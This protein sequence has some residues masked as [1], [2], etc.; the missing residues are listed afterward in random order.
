[1]KALSTLGLERHLAI[2]QLKHYLILKAA[3]AGVGDRLEY[4]RCVDYI[5]T[6]TTEWGVAALQQAKGDHH[7]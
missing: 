4:R 5:D 1:M 6:L 7:V 2:A 3:A